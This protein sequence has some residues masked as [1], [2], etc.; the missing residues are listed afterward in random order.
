MEVTNTPVLEDVGSKA[1]EKAT[2]DL[3]TVPINEDDSRFFLV[4]STMGMAEQDE[5]I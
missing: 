4:S 2:E 5:M 1:E 3:V